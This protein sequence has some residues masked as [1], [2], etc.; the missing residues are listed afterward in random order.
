MLSIT[1][2][3]IIFISVVGVTFYVLEITSI[4]NGLGPRRYRG[5]MAAVISV[6]M[7]MLV[8]VFAFGFD[9]AINSVSSSAGA[10]AQVIQSSAQEPEG[11]TTQS[12]PTPINYTPPMRGNASVFDTGDISN[13]DILK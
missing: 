9:I 5:A 7:A 4:L 8:M 13:T 10:P 2:N 6:V 12:L 1:T 11:T 3:L